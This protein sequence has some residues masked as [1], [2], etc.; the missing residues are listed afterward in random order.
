MWLTD[1]CSSSGKLLV[2][3][4]LAFGAPGCQHDSNGSDSRCVLA[5]QLRQKLSQSA[6]KGSTLQQNTGSKVSCFWDAISVD[7][8]LQYC[9]M[10]QRS[11]KYRSL[12][13]NIGPRQCY[14]VQSQG[15][16]TR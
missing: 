15:V 6:N 13:N 16:R 3:L 7:K 14:E 12:Y 8:A 1:G 5:Q 10:S 11:T 4:L 2:Q 9:R